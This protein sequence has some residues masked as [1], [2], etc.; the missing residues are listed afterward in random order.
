MD[1]KKKF[2]FFDLSD[3]SLFNNTND[4]INQIKPVTPELK[5]ITEK[6]EEINSNNIQ[7]KEE[8]INSEIKTQSNN[9]EH[10]K[11]NE[12]IIQSNTT[13][14]KNNS[15]KEDNLYPKVERYEEKKELINNNIKSN[16]EEKEENVTNNN[17][18]SNGVTN[19]GSSTNVNI[20]SLFDVEE[21]LDVKTNIYIKK[22]I[23]NEVEKIHINTG[24]SR[25]AVIN[26]LL[27][28]ALK[29]VK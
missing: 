9:F 3:D 17:Y 26:K 28:Y 15:I 14:V 23:Y 25:S 4:E 29:G 13:E 2:S 11:F 20:N 5:P 10:A 18:I 8:T 12:P 24:K 19:T 7:Q 22:W 21:K 6:I 1:K 16:I 27:E